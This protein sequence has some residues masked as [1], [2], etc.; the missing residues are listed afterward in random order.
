MSTYYVGGQ[1]QFTHTE[2]DALGATL[3]PQA[4]VWHSS[5]LSVATIDSTGLAS[6][7]AAGETELSYV[8]GDYRRAALFHA[9]VHPLVPAALSAAPSS[10]N[11]YPEGVAQVQITAADS[12]GHPITDFAIDSVVSSDPT[13][14]TAIILGPRSYL[15][16]G[17]A[18][19]SAQITVFSGPI[20][21]AFTVNVNAPPGGLSLGDADARYRQLGV[22]I[23]DSQISKVVAVEHVGSGS[24]ISG[25]LA[26]AWTLATRAHHILLSGDLVVTVSALAVGDFTH[27]DVEQDATGGHTFTLALSGLPPLVD[28]NG[29]V[30]TVTVTPSKQDSFLLYN[31]GARVI[32]GRTWQNVPTS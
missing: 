15:A 10:V 25:T 4:G 24:G 1:T 29:V 8:L 2:Y 7:L 28:D 5:N 23:P 12:G 11:V 17:I 27:F 31:Q 18:L 9:V 26:I 3:A 19:G 32:F 16:L 14:A 6:W 30:P 22:V 20:S 13:V 21:A